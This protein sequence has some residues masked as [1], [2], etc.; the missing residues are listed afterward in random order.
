MSV[1]AAEQPTRVRYAVLAFLCVLAFIFYVD[2]L[3]ISTAAIKIEAD[4]G[5]SHE[6]M[7]LIF[8][9]FTLAYCLFEV[10][11]GAWGDR[12]GSRGVMTRIVVWWSFFT[13][14]T[15]TGFNLWSMIAIRFLFGAGEAGAFP[16]TAR[17]LVRWFPV[18]RRGSSQGVITTAA[19]LGGAVA[20][21]AA[22]YLIGAVGWRGAF[23]IFALPGVVWAFV[24]YTWF[25][26]DPGE[27]PAVND[28]ERRLIAGSSHAPGGAAHP[29][30]PWGAVLTN[31]NVWLLGTITTCTAF[32]TYLVFFWYPTYLEL[33]RAASSGTAAGWSSVVLAAGAVGGA[34][35]GVLIDWVIRRT[36]NR[37]R[38]RR[39]LGFVAL[40]LGACCIALSVHAD[41]VVPPAL[42]MAGA[43]FLLNATL[44][45]WWGAVADISG[46]HL[47]ALF[48]LMN[49]MG[50]VGAFISPIFL[51]R[52]ADH[53]K[54]LGHE[55]RAQWDPAFYVYALVLF[56][57]ALGWLFVDSA[58]AIR[59][60]VPAEPALVS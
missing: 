16:N 4:L 6:Q 46:C 22:A 8:S 3:C 31:R 54:A 23:I 15:A 24:F 41:G 29:P 57:G 21:V 20:P 28:A 12:Y 45:N 50:G 25:R 40:T 7:G 53:M 27:H 56:T 55:G 34:A 30:I 32:N 58:R 43:M 49:S 48:G 13:A 33:G 19:L 2:R 39:G 42:C 9:A 5:L 1:P 14:L 26:D 60:P 59:D 10:P 52:F 17:I 51:G 44:A 35:G 47:G 11:T 37:R 38:S 36:G 18:E